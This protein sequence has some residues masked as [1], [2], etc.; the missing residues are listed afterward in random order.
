M[1][2]IKIVSWSL[3][4]FTAISF[5][6]VRH[7][8]THRAAELAHGAIPGG[9]LT[10]FHVADR[11]GLLSGVDRELS[12]R[13]LRRTRIRP[14]LQRSHPPVGCAGEAVG[15]MTKKGTDRESRGH[16]PERP[17]NTSLSTKAVK[18]RR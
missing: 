7:L 12:L 2:N 4:L 11:G 1:L 8:R 17:C 6:S 9:G 5:V 18:E 16:A 15:Y 14:H 13:R 3:G 10:G